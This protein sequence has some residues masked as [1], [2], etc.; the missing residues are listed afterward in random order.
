MHSTHDLSRTAR[1]RLHRDRTG[2]NSG[3]A[4]RTGG[5]VVAQRLGNTAMQRLTSQRSVARPGPKERQRR[6]AG[7]KRLAAVWRS[8]ICHFLGC[9]ALLPPCNL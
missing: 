3:S 6:R 5:E 4:R 7:P 8:V 9:A 1:R 2:D